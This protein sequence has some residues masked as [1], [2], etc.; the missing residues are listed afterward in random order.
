MTD[1]LRILYDLFS[2]NKPISEFQMTGKCQ[3]IE[4]NRNELLNIYKN[5]YLS[6]DEIY[7]Y[8]YNDPCMICEDDIFMILPLHTK[9]KMLCDLYLKHNKLK[10]LNI[11]RRCHYNDDISNEYISVFKKRYLCFGKDM[12]YFHC[13][14]CQQEIYENQYN[15]NY[16]KEGITFYYKICYVCEREHKQFCH[17]SFKDTKICKKDWSDKLICFNMILNRGFYLPLDIKV[18][19]MDMIGICC[20]K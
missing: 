4:K 6:N 14:L 16:V 19:I 9:L 3:V 10:Q 11:S 8:H 15:N 18:Y 13:V 5:G 17:E 7:T 12:C 20:I 1:R 2:L